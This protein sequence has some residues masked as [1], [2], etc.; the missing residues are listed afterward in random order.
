MELTDDMRRV[1]RE[2]SL[3]FVATVRPDGTPALS[4]KGTTSLLLGREW[5]T[6]PRSAPGRGGRASASRPGRPKRAALKDPP[7]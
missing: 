3:G 2:Q 6:E 1:V 7:D 4:P 5:F